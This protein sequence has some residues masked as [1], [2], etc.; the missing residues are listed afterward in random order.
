MGFPPLCFLSGRV[1]PAHASFR[2][3]KVC[4]MAPDRE[5]T[6]P[7]PGASEQSVHLGRWAR[8]GD[9]QREAAHSL[10]ATPRLAL[11]T[12]PGRVTTPERSEKGGAL[13]RQTDG[14][15]STSPARGCAGPGTPPRVQLGFGKPQVNENRE[16]QLS[17]EPARIPMAHAKAEMTAEPTPLAW[18]E[19]PHVRTVGE[20]GAA[21][22]D[23]GADDTALVSRRTKGS[24]AHVW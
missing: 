21:T 3:G 2:A 1:Q 16:G 23:H 14:R 6:P 17:R 12:G 18:P 19:L 4:G 7:S 11:D 15:G 20:A 9:P 10:P 8:G 22:P 5:A 13:G 24:R